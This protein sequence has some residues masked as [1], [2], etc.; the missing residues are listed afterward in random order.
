[1]KKAHRGLVRMS[2]ALAFL[3]GLYG[4]SAESLEDSSFQVGSVFPELQASSVEGMPVSFRPPVG[5]FLLVH[6]WKTADAQIDDAVKDAVVL[7]KR[8]HDSGLN[9]VSIFFDKAEDAVLEF[10]QRWQ[11]P[12]AQVMEVE[13]KN[14]ASAPRNL[15]L[16]AQGKVLA[17]NLKG[18]DAHEAIAKTLN[19]SLDRLPM[20]APPTERTSDRAPVVVPGSGRPF[21]GGALVIQSQMSDSL[22]GSP[23]EREEVEPCRK[24]LR[25]ISLALT[26]YR[27]DH[28]GELPQWPSDLFPKYLQDESVLLCPSNPSPPNGLLSLSD[29]KMKCSYVYEFA[30]TTEL[31]GTPY[32]D[33]K[34]EQMKQYGDKVPV[35]RCFNHPRA[36]S[37][38]Y[39]GEIY[40]TPNIRWEDSF[41]TGRTLDDNDV[42]ARRQLRELA[43]AL[44]KFKKDKG[45]LPNELE[46][47]VPNYIQDSSLQ[48]NPSVGES[49]LPFYQFTPQNDYRAQKTAQ[50]K[51]FGE[52]V[53]V[54]RVRG[55]LKEDRVINLA[56][57]GEIW[58]SGS[59][60][61]SDLQSP[62]GALGGVSIGGLL[63]TFLQVM[64]R[65]EES[66]LSAKQW[67]SETLKG[68]L[69]I[70]KPG[71]VFP[72]R[73]L[74]IWKSEA[75]EQNLE[76]VA[77]S[78]LL[79]SPIIEKG[80]ITMHA[81]P[82]NGMEGVRIIF[83]YAA[84]DKYFVFNIGGFQNTTVN[85]EK[86]QGLE[87]DSPRD[88]SIEA[89]KKPFKLEPGKWHDIRVTVDASEGTV[90]CYV[91]GQS[92]MTRQIKESLKGR[93]GV[94]TWNTVAE[95][96][97]IEITGK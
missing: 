85:I 5:Q 38:S 91:D 63:T 43:V 89:E 16:D 87:G 1:M 69:K 83:G 58:E 26:E 92:I 3:C 11:I 74:W 81:R 77:P 40:L 55:V 10:S 42:K 32:R 21:P 67:P 48:K 72:L 24:N 8:F 71:Q 78:S 84:P 9:V 33:W 4:A 25:K 60:W 51:E 73:G 2:F 64:P 37:M 34:K 52:Y 68:K 79:F 46:E 61:E 27:R 57:N 95:F 7:Y 6:F 30:P 80:E 28:N 12:W 93:F 49:D 62:N 97:S 18:N 65:N 76:P 44:D 17:V 22:L 50:L 54:L 14:E 13:V 35:L 82:V 29:P 36:L 20:P 31:R 88:L 47:L 19:V 45:E 66:Q 96:Q 41:S 23:Q 56:Y 70:E 39:G 75:L 53:P 59:A 15:L 86:W 90:E 94:G